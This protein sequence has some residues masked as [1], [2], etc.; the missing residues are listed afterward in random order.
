[1][2][3]FDE[4]LTPEERDAPTFTEWSDSTLARGVRCLA[5]KL[6]DSVGF[7]GITGMAAALAL[8]KIAQ[9]NNAETYR[10]TI[11]GGTIITVSLPNA[12]SD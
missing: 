4:T 1:M 6:H 3:N 9:D 8:E 2:G 5:S 11:D 10:I 12:E 7:Q